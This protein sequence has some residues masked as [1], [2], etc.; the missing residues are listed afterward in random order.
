MEGN[1]MV[2]T[3]KIDLKRVVPNLHY[4]SPLYI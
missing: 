4:L 2:E 3:D 1:K